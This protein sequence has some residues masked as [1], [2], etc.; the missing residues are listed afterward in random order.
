MDDEDGQSAGIVK[1]A[2]P[3]DLPMYARLNVMGLVGL[4]ALWMVFLGDLPVELALL[5][6]W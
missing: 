3:R 4:V 1:P 6:G 5:A 2:R